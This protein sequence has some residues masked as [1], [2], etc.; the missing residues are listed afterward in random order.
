MNLEQAWPNTLSMFSL[1][2][3]PGLINPPLAR[4]CVCVQSYMW[5]EDGPTPQILPARLAQPWVAVAAA[6]D[7]PPVLV[8]ATYN[9]YN[10]RKIDPAGPIALGNICCLHNFFG[11]QVG[12]E[13]VLIKQIRTLASR[14]ALVDPRFCW[15]P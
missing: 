1:L 5:C 9:L 15:E 4:T 11:G 8:Y 14:P 12:A 2:F 3:V 13:L 7:M 10:W 6:L